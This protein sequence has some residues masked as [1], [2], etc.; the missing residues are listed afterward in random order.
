MIEPQISFILVNN[1]LQEDQNSSNI[2][3][4]TKL[5][6]KPLLYRIWKYLKNTWT[7][8]VAGNGKLIFILFFLSFG[9]NKKLE[10][11]A[12]YLLH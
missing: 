3:I 7:Q 12:A 11:F 5:Q 1:E 2:N 6:S 8:A 4:R 9:G 10:F